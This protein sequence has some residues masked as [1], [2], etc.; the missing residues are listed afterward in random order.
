AV[1][2]WE[3]ATGKEILQLQGHSATVYSL[4]FSQ[5]G[6]TLASGSADTT[7]LLWDLAPK[8]RHAALQ[9]RDLGPKEL[10]KLWADLG[11]EDA[12]KAYQVCWTLAVAPQRAVPFLQERLRPVPPVAEARIAQRLADLDSHQFTVREKAAVELQELGR[13]AEPALRR[14]LAGHVPPEVRRR[15]EATLEKLNKLVLFPEQLRVVRALQAL[16]YIGT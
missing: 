10:D 5:D 14:A 9:A 3:V 13:A 16:E 2:L 4:T 7:V 11:S 12:P 6:N 15:A 1:R 8:G